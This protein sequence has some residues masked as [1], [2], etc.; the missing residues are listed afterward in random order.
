MKVRV[1]LDPMTTQAK[2]ELRGAVE[3]AFEPVLVPEALEFVGELQRQFGP[4]RQ[5]LLETR[6]ERRQRLRRCSTSCP[7]P[8]RSARPTGG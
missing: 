7:R 5:E 1:R 8:G 4:R 2:L 3:A 6:A